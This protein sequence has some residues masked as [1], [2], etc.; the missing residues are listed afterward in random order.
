MLL[1]NAAIVDWISVN[2]LPN[3]CFLPP[4]ALALALAETSLTSLS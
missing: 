2:E 4:L 3:V 1:E